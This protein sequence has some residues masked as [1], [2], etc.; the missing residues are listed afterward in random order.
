MS[1]GAVRYL[2][3]PHDA[4]LKMASCT[5]PGI[6]LL[7]SIIAAALLYSSDASARQIGVKQPEIVNF[8][9]QVGLLDMPTAR[10][11]PDGE[12]GLTISSTRVLDR[13]NLNFQALP[14]L[15]AVF[16]YSRVDRA[17]NG[18]DLYD[19]SLSFKIRLAQESKYWP[20]IAVGVEDILGTGAFGAEY[21][22]ASKKFENFDVSAGIGW[23]RFGGLAQFSNPFGLAFHSFKT[24]TNDFG[25][26]GTPSLHSYFRGRKVGLFGGISWQ[27]PING[28]ALIAEASGD[29]YT[30]EQR[31]GAINIRTPFNFGFSYEPWEGLQIGGGYFYGSQF[32][33]RVSLHLNALDDQPNIRLGKKPLPV[34]T[35]SPTARKDSVLALLQE[36]TQFYDNNPWAVTPD[37]SGEIAQTH[38]P[39]SPPVQNTYASNRKSQ[40]PSLSNALYNDASVH[41]LTIENVESYGNALIVSISDKNNNLSC[42]PFEKITKAARASGFDQ[43]ILTSKNTSAVQICTSDSYRF[44]AKNSGA[45][46]RFASDTTE[47]SANNTDGKYSP[48]ALPMPDST[49]AAIKEKVISAIQQ[50]NI[51]VFAISVSDSKIEIAYVNT[52]YRTDA[53]AIGRLL[54]VLMAT[55]PDSVE[56]FRL[57]DITEN[58]PTNATTFMRSDIERT[59]NMSGAA[60]ELRP[61]NAIT[62]VSGNDP[63]ITRNRI[64]D[65]PKFGFSISPG[66]RQSL[67]DPVDPYR[68]QLYANVGAGISLTP[69]LT[70]AGSL[71]T[72]IYNNFSTAR[73]S[74]SVLPHVRSDFAQYYTKGTVAISSI[75][76]SY[77]DKL[78]PQVYVLAKAGYLENMYAGVGGEVLWQPPQKRWSIGASLYAVQQRTFNRMFGLRDYKTVTGHVS[79]Y[80]DSP[81]YDFDFAL[82]V[83]RYLAKDYGATL[84]ITRRFSN[85]IEI[86]A[87]ATLTNVPFSKFGEGS[88]DK[89][90]IIRIPVE[91]LAPVYTQDTVNLDF[92][93]L[94]RDGGQRLLGESSLHGLLRRSS[95]GELLS[96]WNKVLNP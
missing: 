46:I 67:F 44:D 12:L 23:R 38:T 81:F 61:L 76:A 51:G 49:N 73:K 59:L 77:F 50:Q 71:E 68:L 82:H 1:V 22:V 24:D 32:G 20:N 37:V 92:T 35:R 26:G 93:P 33:F 89:G 55:A 10:F 88:F 60:S 87:F 28:L 75:Q 14:W 29:R 34:S 85:G 63:L 13:Y 48:P 57:T 96:N 91:A 17:S 45:V 36:R 72:N 65:Y 70:V 21:L 19:R 2:G 27:T 31:T 79:L 64:V 16:R 6:A 41:S 43:I 53:E 5:R 18:A 9:G 30:Q 54:R 8:Y 39:S 80:Y 66:Y 25:Q 83:G 69:H 4:F 52:A 42:V 94:T 62:P 40:I 15:E 56:I 11:A 86:G 3:K 95:E 78:T 74:D 84:Q 7:V 58:T 90:F 47:S